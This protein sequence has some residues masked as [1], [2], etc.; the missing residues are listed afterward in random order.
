MLLASF[1]A[2]PTG[3]AEDATIYANDKLG[4]RLR[5]GM[6]RLLAPSR[7]RRLC[8]LGVTSLARH[9][10]ANV[11]RTTR[12]APRRV[13]ITRLIELTTR[14]WEGFCKWIL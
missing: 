10:R 4:A 14:C 11:L 12:E 7:L 6:G 1:A 5:I 8:R 9:P 3:K 2:D 13:S